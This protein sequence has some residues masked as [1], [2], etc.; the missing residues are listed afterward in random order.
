MLGSF[1][2][3]CLLYKGADEWGDPIFRER[4]KISAQI[5]KH[6]MIDKRKQ[7]LAYR[8]TYSVSLRYAVY[9]D[10][11]GT[12]MQCWN[13]WVSVCSRGVLWSNLTD[14]WDISWS[15]ASFDQFFQIFGISANNARIAMKKLL[16][17]TFDFLSLSYLQLSLGRMWMTPT[18]PLCP[19]PPLLLQR[20]P[21]QTVPPPRLLSS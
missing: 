7:N 21:S 11:Y 20:L 13:S 14:P 12:S 9:V 2:D 5:G 8:K 10:K 4:P 18:R 17:L 19:P 16:I 15:P 3:F 1:I 6:C